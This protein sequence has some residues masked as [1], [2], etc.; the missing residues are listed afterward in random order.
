M[1]KIVT[2]KQAKCGG[3]VDLIYALAV[4]FFAV[5]LIV[6]MVG[7]GGEA[8]QTGQ[9]QTGG[10]I[11]AVT[12]PE[13]DPSGLPPVGTVYTL[14]KEDVVYGSI[15]Y[16]GQDNESPALCVAIS[17]DGSQYHASFSLEDFVEEVI[18]DPNLTV[19]TPV[20]R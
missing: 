16:L 17:I 7:C 8:N 9:S 5:V 6:C 2:Q 15:T 4:R 14:K 12:N 18:G 10:E 11:A 13:A 20:R 3:S 1:R 19:A